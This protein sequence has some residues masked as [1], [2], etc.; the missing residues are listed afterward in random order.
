[1]ALGEIRRNVVSE[2]TVD[3]LRDIMK[4]ELLGGG[5]NMQNSDKGKKKNITKVLYCRSF[6]FFLKKKSFIFDT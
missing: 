4:C 2:R 3:T 6:K 5:G 1:M